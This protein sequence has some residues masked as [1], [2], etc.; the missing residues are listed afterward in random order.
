M[1]G[2]IG[3]EAVAYFICGRE[4][5]VVAVDYTPRL[6]ED[7]GVDFCLEDGRGIVVTW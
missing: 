4:P 5:R 6:R 3:E 1:V 7:A 2:K